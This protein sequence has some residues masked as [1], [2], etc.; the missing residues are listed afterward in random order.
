MK[1]GEAPWLTLDRAWAAEHELQ[2]LMNAYH[3]TCSNEAQSPRLFPL[4][5]PSQ[6]SLIFEHLTKR[7]A[8]SG[9]DSYFA[10]ADERQRFAAL[11]ALSNPVSYIHGGPGTGKT[12]IAQRI[13]ALLIELQSLLGTPEL[14]VAITAPTGKAAVRVREAIYTLDTPFYPLQNETREALR[15]LKISGVTLHRLLAYHPDYPNRLKFSQDHPLPY[16]VVIVDEASMLELPLSRVLLRALPTDWG[17]NPNRPLQRLI[18]L[19]DPDQLPPV[20]EGAVW[21]DLCRDSASGEGEIIPQG[22]TIALPPRAQAVFDKIAPDLTLP[23]THNNLLSERSAELTENYRLK[24]DGDDAL[25][26]RKIFEFFDYVKHGEADLAIEHLITE[27]AQEDSPFEW[28]RL[29]DQ[30][31]LLEANKVFKKD[32]AQLF[33]ST[34]DYERYDAWW[35]TRKKHVK[36]LRSAI[37]NVSKSEGTDELS[38]HY[39]SLEEQFKRE[40]ILC[41]QYKGPYG[42]EYFNKELANAR[43]PKELLG[44]AHPILILSNHRKTK[45]YNGDIGFLWHP[46][47]QTSAAPSRAYFEAADEEDT[48]RVIDSSRLPSHAHVYAMSVHKSQGSEFE[49]VTV[50]LPTFPSPL[51]TRELLYTAVTRTQSF[52]RI[53]ASKEGLSRAIKKRTKR[54]TLTPFI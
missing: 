23:L 6:H 43:S 30:E 47:D 29:N 24:G 28:I 2:R 52:I 51:L 16:D 7:L 5:D 18:F 36:S 13:L 17:N 14:R 19:G 53:I 34:E 3:T 38:R 54:F 12:T 49:S 31:D 42:V 40:L 46:K 27:N 9:E 33:Y 35:K 1:E 39:I 22:Q 45:L 37:K 26:K 32:S 11:I 48:V 20:G 10:G 21:R 8:K 25:K 41:A 4:E 50:S 44:Q 15:T